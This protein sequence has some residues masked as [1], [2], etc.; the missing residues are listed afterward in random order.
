MFTCTLKAA[1]SSTGCWLSNDSFSR[2]AR[3]GVRSRAVLP[4]MPRCSFTSV[5]RRSKEARA[6]R[7]SDVEPFAWAWAAPH[8]RAWAAANLEP[9]ESARQEGPSQHE[10]AE[11]EHALEICIFTLIQGAEDDRHISPSQITVQNTKRV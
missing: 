4:R 3:I 1:D 7:A 2:S 9:G 10:R 6:L 8:S 11:S 5:S